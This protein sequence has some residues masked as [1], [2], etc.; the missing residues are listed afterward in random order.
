[1]PAVLAAPCAGLVRDGKQAGDGLR[2]HLQ[3]HP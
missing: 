1:M 3:L 2:R